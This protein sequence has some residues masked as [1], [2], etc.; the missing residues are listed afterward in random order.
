MM[1]EIAK[2]I[3]VAR[4]ESEREK[5]VSLKITKEKHWSEIWKKDD[6]RV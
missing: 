1:D 5:R 3:T 6:D 4:R 2:P